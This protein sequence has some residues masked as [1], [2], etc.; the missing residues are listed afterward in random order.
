MEI[1][2]TV[3]GRHLKQQLGIFVFPREVGRHIVSRNRESE[4]TSLNVAFHHHI[5]V[6]F[7]DH[8]HFR[9]EVAISKRLF[10]SGNQRMLVT[11]VFGANPVKGKVGKRRLRTPARRNVQIINQFLKSLFDLF[12]RKLVDTDIRSQIGVNRRKSL[13]TGPFVLQRAHKVD[14]LPDGRRQMFGRT[15]LG[16][17]GNT[18]KALVQQILQRPACAISRQHIKVVNMD[19]AVA[20][21]FAD[22]GRINVA[23]PVVGGYFAGN[24][25]DQTAVGIPLIGVGVDA[26]VE[27]FEIFVDRAFDVNHDLFLGAHAMTLFAVKDIRLGGGEIVGGDQYLFNHILNTF[28]RRQ[29]FGK[30]VFQNFQNLRRQQ[31][32]F[33]LAEFAGRLTGL[34]DGVINFIAVK[35]NQGAVPFDDVGDFGFLHF[36]NAVFFFRHR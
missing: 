12:V 34:A 35:R 8:I 20:V 30:F 18:V 29:R 31:I 10:N 25:Q 7:V 27:F 13:S 28:N 24:V 1:R 14:H 2:Q 36:A 3:F 9:L 21:R 32:A 26:P 22:F 11:Q 5:D 4:R 19:V 23:Q 33:L 15:R 17:A 6:S 16:F